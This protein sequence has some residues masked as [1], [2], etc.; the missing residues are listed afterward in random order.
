[1]RESIKK[2]EVKLDANRFVRVHR[3]AITKIAVQAT[4]RYRRF[5][6]RMRCSISSVI[7]SASTIVGTDRGCWIESSAIVVS[8]FLQMSAVNFEL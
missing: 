6:L 4:E 3:T 5:T 1:M 2:L 7:E 8:L